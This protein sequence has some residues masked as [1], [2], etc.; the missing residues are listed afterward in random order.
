MSDSDVTLTDSSSK[1][2]NSSDVSDKSYDADSDSL[3][4]S[5]DKELEMTE[6]EISIIEKIPNVSLYLI[7]TKDKLI[8]VFLTPDKKNVVGYIDNQNKQISTNEVQLSKFNTTKIHDIIIDDA[9]DF[10]KPTTCS[11][12][13][14]QEKIKQYNIKMNKWFEDKKK[15][16][17]VLNNKLKSE[18][19]HVLQQQYEQLINNYNIELVKHKELQDKLDKALAK[20]I[21]YKENELHYKDK[22]VQ[23]NK[24]KQELVS[25]INAAVDNANKYKVEIDALRPLLQKYKNDMN[26]NNDT[27]K[28]LK[29]DIT[30][31]KN[32]LQKASD[33]SEKERLK[34]ELSNCKKDLGDQ[35]AKLSGLQNEINKLQNNLR[36]SEQKSLDK[37][38][39]CLKEKTDATSRINGLLQQLGEMNKN[40]MEVAALKSKLENSQRDL[41]DKNTTIQQLKND[42][43]KLKGD[44]DSL[45]NDIKRANE[46]TSEGASEKDQLKSE[47]NKSK[48]ELKL[49]LSELDKLKNDIKDLQ[50]KL[51]KYSDLEKD[52][53]KVKDQLAT[54]R[55]T[56]KLLNSHLDDLIKNV[57][58]DMSAKK[59]ISET[60]K[61]EVIPE[62]VK[63]ESVPESVKPEVI[64]ESVKPQPVKPQPVKPQPIKPESVKQEVPSENIE[65]MQ[66]KLTI[67]EKGLETEGVLNKVIPQI[68]YKNDPT[69]EARIN[70]R[71]VDVDDTLSFSEKLPYLIGIDNI[72]VIEN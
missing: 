26:D 72:F 25:K 36:I 45:R 37:T 71:L 24:E 18:K 19:D 41:N 16:L 23:Y 30:N 69:M 31:L 5:S 1:K 70:K 40:K 6:D 66:K 48:N 9:Y 10:T 63:P 49:Q 8:G 34:T 33:P 22:D 3:S 55:E 13:D 44:L 21:Q 65:E 52:Y 57:E 64:P 2:F 17:E 67:E 38:R 12:K 28:K 4:Y 54:E 15:E 59:Q 39:E 20:E 53:S 46:R 11:D 50:N 42:I 32:N 60:V 27:I 58:A 35:L 62:S 43:S 61:P 47:L 68:S 51:K 7:Q 56:V 29:D 14:I